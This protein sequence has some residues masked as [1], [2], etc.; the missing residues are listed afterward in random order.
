MLIIA[1][2][3]TSFSQNEFV[4]L[5]DISFFKKEMKKEL[6]SMETIKSDFIQKKHLSF[7]EAPL[8]SKGMFVYKKENK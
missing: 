3:L 1:C 2:G 5:E 8:V 4:E 6:V 7:M